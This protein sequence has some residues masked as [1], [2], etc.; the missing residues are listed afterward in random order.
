MNPVLSLEALSVRFETPGGLVQA[1]QDVSFDLQAG[2]IFAL[3]GETGCGKSV[4]GRAIVGLAGEN[5]RVGGTIRYKGQPLLTHGGREFSRIRGNAVTTILQNPDLALNPVLTIGRQLTEI[6]EHH[7]KIGNREAQARVKKSLDQMGF[8]HSKGLM[9]KYP[10]QLSGGMNQRILIAAAMLTGPDLIIADEPT[11]AVDARLKEIIKNRLA[12]CRDNSGTAVLLITHDLELA[13]SLA[14]RVGVMAAGKVVEVN[15]MSSFLKEPRHTYSKSLIA[16]H[17][18]NRIHSIPRFFNGNGSGAQPCLMLDNLAKGFGGNKR[19]DHYKPIFQE[20]SITVEAGETLGIMGCSGAGKTTLGKIIAGLEKPDVGRVMFRG[21]DISRSIKKECRT[22]RRRVQMI[23][24]D[25]E[26][27]F[28]PRKTLRRSLRDVLNL[29][30]CPPARLWEDVMHRSLQEV[31][32]NRDVLERYPYQLSGGMNQRAALAR[33]LLLEPELIV[34]DEPTSALDLTVQ[35]HMLNLLE[36]LK[37]DKKLSY[38][39]ISHDK[40]VI[41]TMCDRT[42]VLE[43]GRFIL[44]PSIAVGESS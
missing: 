35:D 10:F 5:A 9:N 25:P 43:N 7:L 32:L 18:G 44:L 14:Q 41:D 33:V 22:Y 11:R 3:V 28:N 17:K 37:N 42:G 2:E 39:L 34:L 20:V 30:Q 23:F 27:S 16:S 21:K 38:I 36:Q 4:T 40:R 24:Q 31:G 26:G 6:L 29:I 1:V 13:A 8:G 12:A 15:R 19:K